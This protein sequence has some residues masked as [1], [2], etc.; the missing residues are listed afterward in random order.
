MTQGS[1]TPKKLAYRTPQLVVYG[2]VRKVTLT[3]NM[4]V[5]MDNPTMTT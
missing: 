5:A 1:A 2:D 3:A 4:G